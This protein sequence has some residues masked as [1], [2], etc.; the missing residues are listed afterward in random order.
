M[1]AANP[2]FDAGSTHVQLRDIQVFHGTLQFGSVACTALRP[3][4]GAV[5]RLLSTCTVGGG[6]P[7]PVTPAAF[8]SLLET[9]SFTNGKADRPLVAKLYADRYR[10]VLKPA[11]ALRYAGFAWGDE[12]AARVAEVLA[13]GAL[14]NLEYLDLSENDISD[15]GAKA[16]AVALEILAV[17][18]ELSRGVR[19]VLARL[20]DRLDARVAL[21]GHLGA[22]GGDRAADILQKRRDDAVDVLH[23]RHQASAP[24]G[25]A[26]TVRRNGARRGVGRGH[27]RGRRSAGVERGRGRRSAGVDVRGHPGGVP[28]RRRGPEETRGESESVDHD[29][30]DRR[31]ETV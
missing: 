24:R 18:R 21:G 27:R 2:D 4:L 8:S 14:P 26:R 13:S 6:R 1:L 25:R 30:W 3:E 20:V 11:R 10:S 17:D 19:D 15:K 9:L 7:P 16:L 5:S 31:D 29:A 22:D 28:R 23:R 12:E